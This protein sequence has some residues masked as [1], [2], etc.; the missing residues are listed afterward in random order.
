M[1]L[2]AK[3]DRRR[4]GRR[5]FAPGVGMLETRA[6]M[7]TF[8]VSSP[9]DS[10]P[11]TLRQ[12]VLDANDAAGADTIVFDLGGSPS[13]IALTS[14]PLF[15]ADDLTIDGPGAGALTVSAGGAGAVFVIGSFAPT[16]AASVPLDVTIEGLTVADGS[17]P[18]GFGGGIYAVLTDLTVR[19]AAFRDNASSYTGGAIWIGAGFYQDEFG[20]FVAIPGSLTVERT[21]FTGNS[22]DAY[23]G[24]ISVYDTPASVVDGTFTGNS[25]YSGGAINKLDFYVPTA[26]LNVEGGTFRDNRALNS[27]GALGGGGAITVRNSLFAGNTAGSFGGGAIAYLQGGSNPDARLTVEGSRFEGNSVSNAEF[28]ALGGALFNDSRAVIRDST[29][30]DN[31]ASAP[32]IAQGGAIHNGFS[33]ELTV[34]GSR[35]ESNVARTTSDFAQEA[36]GGALSGDS[37]SA[38]TVLDSDFLGNRAEGRGFNVLGGAIKNVGADGSFGAPRDLTIRG[39]RFEGN[40]AVGLDGAATSPFQQGTSAFGG[41][42]YSGG[43]RLIISDTTFRGNAAL[44][45]SLGAANPGGFAGGGAVSNR[46]GPMTLTG[47][48]FEGNAARGGAGSELGWALGGALADEFRSFGD[49]TIADS[50]FA[51]NEAVAGAGTGGFARGGA[52]NFVTSPGVFTRIDVSGNRAVGASGVNGG[53][54]FGGGVSLDG[55]DARI[56]DSHFSG[57]LAQGGNAAAGG[58]AGDASGGAIYSN[59]LFGGGLTLTGSHLAGNRARGGVGSTG[60]NAYGGGLWA[61]G[62]IAVVDSKFNGN[63]ADAGPAGVGYGGGI[64]VAPGST[65]SI[66]KK[67]KLAGNKA[68]TAGDNLF[69]A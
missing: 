4:A 50:R 17:A 62:V 40:A 15:I 54:A 44:G 14:G 7:A 60:G 28:L 49:S 11:G 26:P 22:A 53:D 31:L 1:G 24:A 13:T 66:D 30:V 45:G 41:A 29:F 9:L 52:I 27:G 37:G 35:F 43:G 16:T 42:V 12:A 33:A 10:G 6:L 3:S 34:E 36:D 61:S 46:G 57:N 56:V 8:I 58:R 51:D 64:Y 21:T 25:A 18:N 38:M 68:T 59:G 65:F 20:Q 63:R 5:R 47:S 39:S 2:F 32:T 48:T 69:Q 55:S 67:S 23:G 19:D